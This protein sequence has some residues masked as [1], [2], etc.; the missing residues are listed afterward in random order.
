MKIFEAVAVVMLMVVALL[1]CFHVPVEEVLTF[2]TSAL[3]LL[4]WVVYHIDLC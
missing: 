2:E 3:S 4:Y 1:T